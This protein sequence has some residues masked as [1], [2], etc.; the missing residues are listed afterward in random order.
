MLRNLAAGCPQAAALDVPARA[1]PPAQPGTSL[2]PSPPRAGV[3]RLQ[4]TLEPGRFRQ[5]HIP[6]GPF[7]DDLDPRH[8][9]LQQVGSGWGRGG[10]GTA[11]P[12]LPR[13]GGG[14]GEAGPGWIWEVR[15]LVSFLLIPSFLSFPSLTHQ[16]LHYI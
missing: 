8:C 12:P 1:S 14:S 3:E 9:P 5:H 16:H 15:P 11:P 10:P 13:V 2:P 6:P 7:G 4:A